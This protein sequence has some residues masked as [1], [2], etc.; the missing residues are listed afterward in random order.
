M[1]RPKYV[2]GGPTGDTGT[3]WYAAPEQLYENFDHTP[4]TDVFTCGL[5]LYEI[6]GGFPVFPPTLPLMEVW[7]RLR[8]HNL[9][10]IPEEF[11]PVMQG[12]I[13]RCWMNDPKDR[14]SFQDILNEF[15]SAGFVILPYA[16]GSVIKDAV[17]KVIEWERNPERRA[18]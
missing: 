14:P 5:V 11:G 16:D 18:K 8:A 3:Y 4:K 9:P 1:S 10:V 15:G 2:E 17:M 6:L 12:L 13:P 7:R